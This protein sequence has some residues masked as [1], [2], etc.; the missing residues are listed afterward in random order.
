M[1]PSLSSI[2]VKRVRLFDQRHPAL[3]LSHVSNQGTE[4]GLDLGVIGG[5]RQRLLSFILEQIELLGEKVRK[6]GHLVSARVGRIELNCLD[7][8]C[9]DLLLLLRHWWVV[10]AEDPAQNRKP[11]PLAARFRIRRIL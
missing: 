7:R 1:I 2:S 4:I 6:R 11:S 8:L 5:K 10:D 9:R 3:P